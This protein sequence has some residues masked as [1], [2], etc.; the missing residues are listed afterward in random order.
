MS[1]A[2]YF[3]IVSP[4]SGFSKLIEKMVEMNGNIIIKID[5]ADKIL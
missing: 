5:N 3:V 1:N 4:E 2:S